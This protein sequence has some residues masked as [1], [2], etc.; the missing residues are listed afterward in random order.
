MKVALISGPHPA[1]AILA[2]CKLLQ[3]VAKPWIL[4]KKKGSRRTSSGSSVALRKVRIFIQLF[5]APSGCIVKRGI[6]FQPL[7][8]GEAI[9]REHRLTLSRQ[10]KSGGRLLAL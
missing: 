7:L 4:T 9:G 8:T 6:N 10:P 3:R 2:S 1:A 5:Y